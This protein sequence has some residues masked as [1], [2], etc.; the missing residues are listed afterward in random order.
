MRVQR[1]LPL[2]R[3]AA[4]VLEL[5]ARG[6]QLLVAGAISGSRERLRVAAGC[7]REELRVNGGAGAALH[8]RSV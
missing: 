5:E 3:E 6:R 1:V 4:H 7:R 8:Q 2:S